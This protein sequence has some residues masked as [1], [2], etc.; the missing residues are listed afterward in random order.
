MHTTD[1]DNRI[2]VKT[3][4]SKSSVLVITQL[5]TAGANLCQPQ[6]RVTS[7]VLPLNSYSTTHTRQLFVVMKY[8]HF[9]K[10]VTTLANHSSIFT[11]DKTAAVGYGS[12]KAA[13]ISTR[14]C[15][16]AYRHT[17]NSLTFTIAF[18]SQ[19]R[20]YVYTYTLVPRPNSP[21]LPALGTSSGIVDRTRRHSGS[22]P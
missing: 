7:S 19:L 5:R 4:G 3:I 17:G 13:S 1:T 15:W 22:S 16:T 10:L 11:H 6:G 8:I 21:R 12:P 20:T 18:S 9:M 14:C 2:V